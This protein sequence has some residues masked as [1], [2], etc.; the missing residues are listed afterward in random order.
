[1]SKK[2]TFARYE[3]VEKVFQDLHAKRTLVHFGSEFSQYDVLAW[4]LEKITGKATIIISSYTASEELGRMLSLLREHGLVEKVNVILDRSAAHNVAFKY[5]QSQT[6]GIRLL[7]NHSKTM[8]VIGDNCAAAVLSSANM[9]GSIRT[10]QTLVT[11][12][13]SI[14]KQTWE[15]L[16]KI[17]S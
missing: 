6:D 3:A 17:V 2:L 11:L 15:Q 16:A 10:E 5:I 9:N 8:V 7:P 4:L 12:D 13:E 1:M 14:V